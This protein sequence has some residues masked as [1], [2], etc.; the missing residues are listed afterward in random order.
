MVERYVLATS[1]PILDRKRDSQAL[2]EVEHENHS[3]D[4][5]GSCDLKAEYF[6]DGFSPG[7][8]II[9]LFVYSL[10]KPGS[11]ETKSIR[12]LPSYQASR[13]KD[14]RFDTLMTLKFMLHQKGS[15]RE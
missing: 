10:S 13:Y 8:C 6:Q 4:T 1:V 14:H 15:W 12:R 7:R 11:L 5:A 3:D 9:S 2:W